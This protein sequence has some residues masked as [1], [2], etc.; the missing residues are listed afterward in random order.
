MAVQSR[1]KGRPSLVEAA[2]IDRAI[3][4]A[5][6]RVLR[7]QGDGATMNAIAMAA[8]LSRKSLYMRFANKTELFLQVIRGVL[9]EVRPIDIPASGDAEQRLKT[10]IETALDV[11][12]R[13]TS[14]AL[15][16]LLATDTAFLAGLRPDMVAASRRLFHEPLI[17]L[18]TEARRNGDFAIEDVDAVALAVLRLVFSESL[19]LGAD[20]PNADLAAHAE[21]LT[22]FVARGLLPRSA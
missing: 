22:R 15:Q 10:F 7:E 1:G 18:L 8:G 19:A 14:K 4:D 2:D 6:L 11:T 21:F 12:S 5:A 3:R 13:P 17:A 9:D 16:Q 20:A